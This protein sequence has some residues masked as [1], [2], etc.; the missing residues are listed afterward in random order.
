[1][2]AKREIDAV[3]GIQA[4]ESAAETN[5]TTQPTPAPVSDA[6]VAGTTSTANT[7]AP[8]RVK[9]STVTVEQLIAM[10]GVPVE[11]GFLL[12]TDVGISTYLNPLQTD[13][14]LTAIIKHRFTDFIVNEI[15]PSGNILHLTATDAAASSNNAVKL[16][17]KTIIDTLPES[18]FTEMRTFFDEEQDENVERVKELVRNG[19]RVQ[20]PPKKDKEDRRDRYNRKEAEKAGSKDAPA[21]KTPEETAAATESTGELAAEK[22]SESKTAETE[23]KD[24][25]SKAVVADARISQVITKAFTDKQDRVRVYDFFRTHF[26][27]LL[28]TDSRGDQKICIRLATPRD[29][30]RSTPRPDFSSTGPGEHLSFILYKENKDTMDCLNTL[31]RVTNTMAKAYT[32]AGTKDKRGVTVQRCSGHRVWQSKLEGVK[33]PPGMKVGGFKYVKDRVNLGDLSANHFIITLRDVEIVKDEQTST[34]TPPISEILSTSL[35]SL[36]ENGFI[37]Y[38]GMQRFGTRSVSTHQVGLAMLSSS[39]ATAIELIMMPKGEERAEFAEA[40]RLWVE[41]KNAKKSFYAFPRGCVAERAV[42]QAFMRET[43]GDYDYLGALMAVPR[44]LRMMYLHSVQSFVWNH[45]ASER[46]RLYGRKIVKGDL[47]AR[48]NPLSNRN[49]SATTMG[50]DATD[51]DTT[52]GDAEAAEISAIEEHRQGRMIEVDLIETDED[53]A[54][55]SIDDLVLPLPGHQVKYPTNEIFAFYKKFMAQYG[56][57]PNDMK[58]H[59]REVSLAGDYRRVLIR[60]KNVSWKVLQYDD[61]HIPL[62]R[63]DLDIINGVPEPVSLPDG[64]RVGVVVEFSLETSS[65]ATMA[66]REI[67]RSDTSAGFQGTLSNKSNQV[68]DAEREK[69][70]A[71]T[72]AAAAASTARVGA[73][74]KNV[75]DMRDE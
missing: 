27:E 62:S 61:P 59:N 56:L 42:M 52:T 68:T 35:K 40:R 13:A 16:D 38:Y 8:K 41:E 24:A 32:F 6:P 33:L 15:D 23:T 2:S 19:V 60:P 31:A 75:S 3:D 73:E 51:A 39:W 11:R 72:A 5:P 30:A 46:I 34:P 10:S 71:A 54:T 9:R 20:N 47:V 53:A 57:D 64:K 48:Y 25:E 55:R 50:E 21:E 43:K 66:L 70:A 44:N 7:P 14:R 49:T 1:M 65:Y 37:N 26:A 45:A 12:E 28:A 58:R 63:T 18:V 67:L 69:A 36:Q 74:D 4:P 29:L 22:A 17:R